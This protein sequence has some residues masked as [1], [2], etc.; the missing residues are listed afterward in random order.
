[1]L[2]D[3][4]TSTRESLA[5]KK[6]FAFKSRR[7]QN[8]NI[9]GDFDTKETGSITTALSETDA[10][11]VS[12]M[13]RVAAHIHPPLIAT[14]TGY[15]SLLLSD[16][17][18]CVVTFPDF[19]F[20]N[21][22]LN[23]IDRSLLLLNGVVNGPAHI[24]GVTNSTL[25]LSCHQFRMHKA[26]NVDVYLMCSSQPIIEDCR[27]IRFAPYGDSTG[28]LWNQVNDFEWLRNEKSPH[29]SILPENER[30]TPWKNIDKG[31]EE[32]FRTEMLHHFVQRAT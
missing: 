32:Q 5:P 21:A 10:E 30:Q 11:N 26:T 1:M 23:N 19:H 6:K 22:S 2:S 24:T 20:R 18:E 27:G 17:L 9:G 28:N 31:D 13:N 3:K 25:V 15:A 4:L 29:W 12:I 7:N 16:L 8:S 14:T